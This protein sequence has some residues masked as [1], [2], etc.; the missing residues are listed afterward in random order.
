MNKIYVTAY[1]D[2][3]LVGDKDRWLKIMTSKMSNMDD[4]CE[5]Q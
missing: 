4:F 3:I 2:Y 5:D 1:G